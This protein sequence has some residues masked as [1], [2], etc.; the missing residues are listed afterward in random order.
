MGWASRDRRRLPGISGQPG[1]KKE[2]WV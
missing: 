1:D 2:G